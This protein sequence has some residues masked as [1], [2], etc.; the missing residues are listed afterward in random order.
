MLQLAGFRRGQARPS[1]VKS[2]DAKTVVR[3]EW[4][5]GGGRGG[6]RFRGL[7]KWVPSSKGI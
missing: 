3:G 2:D 5:R 1:R 6:G 7:G 4:G